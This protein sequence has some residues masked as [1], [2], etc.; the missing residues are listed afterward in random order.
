ME[1]L[2][3]EGGAY[4]KLRNVKDPSASPS[5]PLSLPPC[6][7]TDIHTLDEVEEL[8][9][10]NIYHLKHHR[11]DHLWFIDFILVHQHT[12]TL[13]QHKPVQ[14]DLGR[15]ESFI[16]AH[17]A[18]FMSHKLKTIQFLGMTHATNFTTNPFTYDPPT[19]I[20]IDKDT[21]LRF[22][23]YLACFEDDYMEHSPAITI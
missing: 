13:I 16:L 2:T 17:K 21:T 1:R 9:E 20:K 23:Y 11:D 4:L 3:M 8:K 22:S 7:K 5:L 14:V 6:G 18:K 10:Y 19:T 15:L 12:L